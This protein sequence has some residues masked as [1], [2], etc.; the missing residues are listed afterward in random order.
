ML[1]VTELLSH[2]LSPDH[3]L[4]MTTDTEVRSPAGELG[5]DLKKGKET[6]IEG[7]QQ[8]KDAQVFN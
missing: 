5:F 4:T 3:R 2:A 7:Y 6:K 8:T 1:T